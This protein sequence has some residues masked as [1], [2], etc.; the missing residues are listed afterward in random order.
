M[1]VLTLLLATPVVVREATKA[2]TDIATNRRRLALCLRSRPPCLK[3]ILTTRPFR[4]AAQAEASRSRLV[5]E[6]CDD[7]LGPTAFTRFDETPS[8]LVRS[9]YLGARR[10]PS[11]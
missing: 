1:F 10:R 6:Q 8:K 9:R 7:G 3:S 4:N 11:V 5:G 2:A